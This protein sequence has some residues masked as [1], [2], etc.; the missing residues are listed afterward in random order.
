M[1]KNFVK[2]T[3]CL[4][5]AG[6]MVMSTLLTGCGKKDDSGNG[7][8]KETTAVKIESNDYKK[9]L[10]QFNTQPDISVHDPSI[11]KD[12]ATGKYY[13][14]GSHLAQASSDDMISWKYLGVQG[15][16]N[17]S[18]YGVLKDGL[19]GSFE[20]AGYD[21]SDCKGGYAVWAPEIFYNE[22]YVWEDGSKGAYMMY[23]SA[24]STY[25]RSCIG[26]A[27][28][29]NVE[30]GY[31]Y[32]DTVIYS[33]F[34][35]VDAY[36]KDSDNN[37]NVKYT[38]VMEV[39]GTE[40][41]NDLRGEYFSDNGNGYNTKAFPNAID[42]SIFF[43]KDG[44][45]WMTYGS[46]SG[47]L[48]IVQ[49][50]PATGQV[51]HDYENSSEKDNFTDKYFGKRIAYGNGA[52]GEGP[53]IR[54]SDETG[55]YYLFA[56]I[57]WLGADGGYNMRMFRAENP[58]GPYVDAS[59]RA[60][61]N[62][63]GNDNNSVGVKVMGGYNFPSL[64]TG[65][66]S[67]GHN[68]FI[69]DVEEG[70]NFLVYHTRFVNRG[71]GHQMRVHQMLYNKDGWLCALPFQYTGE[72]TSKTGYTAKEIAGVYNFVD[73]DT[74]TNTTAKGYMEYVLYEDGGVARMKKPE[75]ILGSWKAEE[76]TNYITVSI[77][78]TKSF[79]GVLC[80]MKD[81]AGNSVMTISAVSD[82]NNSVW[83]VKYE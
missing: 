25:C 78:A 5:L 9:S 37:K 2:R 50:D 33:G 16:S 15:Y 31:K 81:E 41:V 35:K 64:N 52:S 19:A 70:R 26:Y 36:D 83:F 38:D 72:T 23:Y 29:K 24:S 4:G 53:Y 58:D 32:V 79:E 17:S 21:D 57:G 22:H 62:M 1:K 67:P 46:W 49:L 20:W 34:T 60:A 45:L 42:P 68:S 12:P 47:G 74:D 80:R 73:H 71:E 18:I 39:Y 82:K 27:V 63:R 13:V 30:S 76:G 77:S 61:T 3:L 54:Y 10:L 6:T 75:K 69:F 48:W 66:L 14:F 51:I 56:T 65:Y 40:N 28:S 11:F 44:K 59:G 43:D 8:G 55:Y 7:G